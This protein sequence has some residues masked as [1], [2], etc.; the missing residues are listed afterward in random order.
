MLNMSTVIVPSNPLKVVHDWSDSIFQI[1]EN[2]GSEDTDECHLPPSKK[3]RTNAIFDCPVDL[4]LG[5]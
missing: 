5:V 2:R 4:H 1:F 3:R